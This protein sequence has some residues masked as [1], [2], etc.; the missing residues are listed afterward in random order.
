MKR[1]L[2]LLLVVA[3]LFGVCAMFTAC[4]GSSASSEKEEEKEEKKSNRV[5]LSMKGVTI[6]EGVVY[7]DN[8]ITLTA[9]EIAIDDDYIEVFFDLENTSDEYR[10]ISCT[11]SVINGLSS[12]GYGFYQS[13]YGGESCEVSLGFYIP[14]LELLQVK[15][16]GHI[17]LYLD[18]S[19]EYYNSLAT[20]EKVTVNT[21][22]KG[23]VHTQKYDGKVLFEKKGVRVTLIET[24]FKKEEE[25]GMYLLVENEN[26]KSLTV[27]ANQV[28]LN[29]WWLPYG[30]FYADLQANTNT[31]VLLDLYNLEHLGVKKEKDIQNI[32]F[33]IWAYDDE[34]DDLFDVETVSYVPGDKDF[35]KELDIGEDVLYEDAIDVVLYDLSADS[36]QLMVQLYIKNHTDDYCSISFENWMVNDYE[37]YSSA[38]ISL[39][40]NAQC[41]YTIYLYPEFKIDSLEELD[42][43]K[44]N[45]SLTS[46]S[47]YE[48]IVETLTLPLD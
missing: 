38:S 21:S 15:T 37:V 39:P 42:S 20:H 30:G 27:S 22:E 4:D 2:S 25:H 34:Y 28:I 14:A 12:S 3:M 24:S 48:T 26:N 9:K 7:E 45:L 23:F 6:E 41:I 43:I 18:I 33:G 35:V 19:D 31:V 17:D 11:G 5:K 47:D 36:G 10:N 1:L 40:E 8:G 16:I 46:Y 44:T 32:T 13:L 29:G